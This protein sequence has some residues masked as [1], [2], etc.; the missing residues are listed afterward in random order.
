M[1]GMELVLRLNVVA[2]SLVCG[3]GVFTDGV[4]C[5]VLYLL[6]IYKTITGG[7]HISDLGMYRNKVLFRFRDKEDGW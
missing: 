5:A 3:D 1:G 2:G 4:V 7:K 6:P